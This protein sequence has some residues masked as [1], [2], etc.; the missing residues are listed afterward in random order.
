MNGDIVP[1]HWIKPNEANRIP[2]RHIVLDTEAHQSEGDRVRVQTFRLACASFDHQ[3]KA[4]RAWR[5]TQRA[6]FTDP[7]SLW[8]WVDDRTLAGRRTIV[9]AHNLAYDLRIADAF[10]HLP[11]LGWRLDMVRLDGGSA[12]CQWRRDKRSLTMVDTVSWFGVKLDKL[13]AVMRMPK[14]SL[15]DFAADDEAWFA[16]CEGDVEILRAAWLRVLEWIEVGKLGNWKPTGA[17]QGWAYLRHAHLT[18]KILHHGVD[19]VAELERHATYTGRCEAWRH[20]KLTGGPFTEWDFAAAY[21]AVAEECDL[22]VRLLGRLAPKAAQRALEP[23]EGVAALIRCRITTDTP[24]APYRRNGGI[25]WPV[26]QFESWLWDVE[27]ATAVAAGATVEAVDGYRYQAAPALRQ[28]AGWVLDRLNEGPRQFDPLLRLVVKGWSRTTVGRFGAQWS[29]WDDFG[30]SHGT[31]VS[32]WRANDGD[33]GERF[34]LMM[35]GG[36]CLRE[37]AR[38]DAPDSSIAVMSFVMAA[39]RV[40]LWKAMATAGLDHVAYVDTDGLIVD[41]DGSAALD[42]ATLPALRPKSRWRRAQVLGPRQLVLDGRLRASGVPSAAVRTGPQ[43]W[44]AEVWRSLPA[45]MRSGELD[46]VVIRDRS[47]RMTGV[48]RR[49]AH[50]PDG[51]TSALVVCD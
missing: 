20:G 34:R 15:P 29:T 43:T 47:F 46:R 41:A 21:A 39:C 1:P 11:A 2:R 12:W 30:E 38:A 9:V 13:G 36:R 10:T 6:R 16:R 22:P 33:T 50:L 3:T 17:G 18:H 5:P 25:L 37:S 23:S 40:K 44:N 4:G 26:G 45:S 24:V 35:V 14:L 7:R 49:R 42:A 19:R 8:E 48:D 51:S 31:D 27:A 28:W 32:L